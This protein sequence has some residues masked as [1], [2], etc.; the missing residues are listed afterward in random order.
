MGGSPPA[1]GQVIS[2]KRGELDTC[3]QAAFAHYHAV[4]REELHLAPEDMVVCGMSLGFADGDATANRLR[5]GREPVT[6]FATF[7][8]GA[9]RAANDG[10]VPHG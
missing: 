4:I 9:A 1:H 3:P 2:R 8:P 10:A 5:T 6:S 7:H